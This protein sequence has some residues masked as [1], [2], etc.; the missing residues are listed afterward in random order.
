MLNT[1]DL[2]R[3]RAEKA[4]ACLILA[5]KFCDEPDSEDAGN[6]MRV[7]RYIFEKEIISMPYSNLFLSIS[8]SFKLT[9]FLKI[10]V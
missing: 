3:V 10:S 7:I 5:D 4:A 9:V 6:I 2:Q 1:A 8:S